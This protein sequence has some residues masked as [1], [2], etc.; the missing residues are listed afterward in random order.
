VV[1]QFE[2]KYSLNI[3]VAWYLKNLGYPIDQLLKL[4]SQSNKDLYEQLVFVKLSLEN[5]APIDIVK[6]LFIKLL[7]KQFTSTVL[8]EVQQ[9]VQLIKDIKF[10]ILKKS[11]T[12]L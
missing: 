4:S 2:S 6:D 7:G 3:D 8:S 11:E 1:E 9:W 10:L 12:V 5:N